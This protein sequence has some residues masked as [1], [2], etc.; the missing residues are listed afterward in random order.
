MKRDL[1][2]K[3]IIK[4]LLFFSMRFRPLK[5]D[6]LYIYLYSEKQ[7]SLKLL[8]LNLQKLVV[9]R[10]VREKNQYYFLPGADF[11]LYK[12]QIP[13]IQKNWQ[14]ARFAAKILRFI[15]FIRMAAVI[16][17]LSFNVISKNSDIDLF[18]IT[19]PNRLYI[20]R[21]FAILILKLLGL[22]KNK[23]NYRG[24]LCLGFYITESNLNLEKIALKPFDPYFYFWLVS[25]TPLWGIKVYRKFLA[26][27][28]WINKYFAN[29]SAQAKLN[30]SADK[31]VAQ[32]SSWVQKIKEVIFIGFLGDF[33][34]NILSSIHIKHTWN[35]AENHSKS[36]TTI[37]Y[38]NILK[39]HAK[40]R[41]LEYK[42]KFISLTSPLSGLK[43]K[44]SLTKR[45]NL[46]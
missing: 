6:E 28:R 1:I 32:N 46:I 12:K 4:T 20:A 24:K 21:S 19:A 45:R 41:R 2:K 15:P 17:S 40:D 23:K 29:F 36:S 14:K 13:I 33:W 22:Y 26:K 5:L 8:K 3:N 34:E 9:E 43:V 31:I 7:I 25:L 39:L 11:N 35:L 18:I 16:N 44:F 30:L 37:A 10:L 38:K 42:N 27:N